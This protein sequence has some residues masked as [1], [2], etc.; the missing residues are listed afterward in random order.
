MIFSKPDIIYSGGSGKKNWTDRDL[1]IARERQ[2]MKR[3]VAIE[4]KQKWK[5]S[6]CSPTH[7]ASD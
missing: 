1:R 2:I 5:I 3:F 7:L 6:V 4:N